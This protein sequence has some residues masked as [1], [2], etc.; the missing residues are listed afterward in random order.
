M[1]WAY[2][3]LTGLAIGSSTKVLSGADDCACLTHPRPALIAYAANWWCYRGISPEPLV[4]GHS[5]GGSW[6]SPIVGRLYTYISLRP[7]NDQ[8]VCRRLLNKQ[9]SSW[10]HVRFRPQRVRLHDGS[11]AG[12]DGKDLDFQRDGPRSVLVTV[13]WWKENSISRLFLCV[14]YNWRIYEIGLWS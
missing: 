2:A 1:L 12:A 4:P 5:T 3:W 7:L 8:R 9:Y 14:C 10:R 6:F 13:N 11:A